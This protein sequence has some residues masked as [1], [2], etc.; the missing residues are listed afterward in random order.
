MFTTWLAQGIRV[1]SDSKTQR[2]LG[3][4]ANGTTGSD[5][6]NELFLKLFNQINLFFD[7]LVHFPSDGAV[8]ILE[9]R[10]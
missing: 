10:F 3:V 9:V 5:L 8:Q 1:Q 7:L 6:M 2:S 4:K